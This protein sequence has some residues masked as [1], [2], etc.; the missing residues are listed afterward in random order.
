MLP[1]NLRGNY[2]LLTVVATVAIVTL[3]TLMQPAT[4]TTR[5]GQVAEDASQNFR[6]AARGREIVPRNM[7][8]ESNELPPPY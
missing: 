7:M 3:I 6:D 2:L 8:Q 4:P 1:L 5:L